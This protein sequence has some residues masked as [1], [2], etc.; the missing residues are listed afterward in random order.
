MEKLRARGLSIVHKAASI[1]A[2]GAL[3]LF[4]IGATL[5]LVAQ[6]ASRLFLLSETAGYGDSYILYDVLRFQR[7]GTIYRDLS[8]P[9]YLPAQYSPLVYILYSL[10]GRITAAANPFVG[11]RLVAL[12]AFVL[13]VVMVVSIVRVLVPARFAWVWGLLLALS[14]NSMR[15]WVLQLRGD[16]PGIFFSL[17]ALRLLLTR[18]PRWLLLAG[19]CAGLAIQF[20]ITFV[21]ALSAGSLWLLLERRWRDMIRFAAAGIVTS[22]GL[23]LLYWLR[24]PRMLSQMLALSPGMRDVS[25]CLRL[26]Y[27]ACTEPVVLLALLA[28]PPVVA[29]QWGR[30]RLLLLAALTSFGVAGVTDVQAGGAANYFFE[31]L[32]T[33]CPAA[34][35]GVLRLLAWG[36]RRT[37][38]ALFTI[39]LSVFYFSQPIVQEM[40]DEG[41]KSLIDFR[42]TKARNAVFRKVQNALRG[43]H[44]FSTVP[45]LAL[46]DPEP[47]LMEPYLLS[48]QERLGKFNPRPLLDRI[49]KGEF[50]VLITALQPISYRG[51]E[52]IGPELRSA[53]DFSYRPYCSIL[54]SLL[55]LP[56][57]R[58]E[59]GGLTEEL[60]RI[61]CVTTGKD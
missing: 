43:R 40:S 1:S 37:G 28:I 32:F 14:I 48:Y 9:P 19:A 17:L 38:V 34:V 2:P 23:Y 7:T 16:F 12:T 58:T 39:A 30:W 47:A 54:G 4:C 25:G 26:M 15:P 24:E 18:R 50:D 57:D 36:R 49:R 61:G 35:L 6:Q 56:R 27:H 31:A 44:V 33:L 20:K 21:A 11:P 53:I 59:D 13:C 41:S 3:F 22:L 52:H 29:H 5:L 46:L 60:N 55:Y 42:G 10:P 8:Q 45:R 51:I